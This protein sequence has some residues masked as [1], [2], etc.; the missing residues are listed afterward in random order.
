MFGSPAHLLP[1]DTTLEKVA[2]SITR[3]AENDTSGIS[4]SEIMAGYIHAGADVDD[5]DVA[6]RVARGRCESGR[7]FLSVKSWDATECEWATP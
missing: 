4:F 2:N 5:F 7:F 6:A 3:A 1:R